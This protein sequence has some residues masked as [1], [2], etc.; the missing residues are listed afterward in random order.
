M[1]EKQIRLPKNQKRFIM[2]LGLDEEEEE[3]TQHWIV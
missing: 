3:D 1:Q 2:L